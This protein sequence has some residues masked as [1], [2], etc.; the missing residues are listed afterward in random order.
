MAQGYSLARLARAEGLLVE[1]VLNSIDP[2]A[3]HEEELRR[4]IRKIVRHWS[5]GRTAIIQA[6]VDGDAAAVQQV[7]NALKADGAALA[8]DLNAR[9]QSTLQAVAQ[10]HTGEW[11]AVVSGAL[12][13]DVSPL[14]RSET[15]EPALRRAALDGASLIKDVDRQTARRISEATFEAFET[16]AGKADLEKTLRETMK[17]PRHR[18]RLIARDQLG[19]FTGYL[20]E[21]RQEE[22]GI[23]TYRWATVGDHRVRPL[24]RKLNGKVFKWAEEPVDGHPGVA[25]ACRCRAEAVIP[26]L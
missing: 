11:T 17:L 8:L 13:I 4:I 14:L 10:W 23:E 25:V 9:Y 19:K 16:G 3:H 20:D 7:L 22:A 5:G 18:A 21:L 2:T 6:Y 15:I 26:G 24:H 1:T 12:D